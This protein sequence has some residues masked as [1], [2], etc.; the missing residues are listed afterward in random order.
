M[1]YAEWLE[2]RNQH[3][4]QYPLPPVEKHLRLDI[5]L[6]YPR[7]RLSQVPTEFN[8]HYYD[9]GYDE[10]ECFY[11]CCDWSVIFD[12]HIMTETP[13]EWPTLRMLVESG[14]R[15]PWGE[16]I[17]LLSTS[18]SIYHEPWAAQKNWNDFAFF[19]GMHWRVTYN[20]NFGPWPGGRVRGLPFQDRRSF[21]W[22]PLFSD[23]E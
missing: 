13:H 19:R 11:V 9:D 5:E 6:S 21:N 15:E 14:H 16:R 12:V 17:R 23:E 3:F 4:A 7:S 8:P 20:E 10:Q 18:S 2:L 22:H 1:R